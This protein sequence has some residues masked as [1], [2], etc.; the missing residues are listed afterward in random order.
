MWS[1]TG[2]VRLVCGRMGH[3]NG[4]LGAVSARVGSVIC[5]VGHRGGRVGCVCGSAEIVDEIEIIVSESAE[6]VSKSVEVL[7]RGD[8]EVVRPRFR[9]SV[10][11]LVLPLHGVAARLQSFLNRDANT[12]RAFPSGNTRS[13]HDYAGRVLEPDRGFLQE[14]GF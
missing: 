9:V 8:A 11:G 2:W 3:R 7:S 13:G 14:H 6:V 12:A 5:Q 4:Q 10:Q 1:V